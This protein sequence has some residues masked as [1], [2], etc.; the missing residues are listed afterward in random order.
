MPLIL[1]AKLH[2]IAVRTRL[3]V[4]E[5]RR[6]ERWLRLFAWEGAWDRPHDPADPLDSSYGL[7]CECPKHDRA[8]R[9]ARARWAMIDPVVP[10][11]AAAA[12]IPWAEA[13]LAASGDVADGA[14]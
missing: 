5:S 3:G 2:T 9:G 4:R 12:I 7:Y 10:A 8:W 14:L 1:P 13:I 6:R 11:L